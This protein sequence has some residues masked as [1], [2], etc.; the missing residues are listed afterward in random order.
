MASPKRGAPQR[1]QRKTGGSPREARPP[2]PAPIPPISTPTWTDNPYHRLPRLR[3]VLH[4][5][6]PTHRRTGT[7]PRRGRRR[8]VPGR[9]PAAVQRGLDA[10]GPRR[11][12]PPGRRPAPAAG[13]G[14]RWRAGALLGWRAPPRGWARGGEAGGTPHRR[15]RPPS[16]RDLQDRPVRLRRPEDGGGP[17]PPA[18]MRRSAL[19]TPRRTPAA[20]PSRPR[21]RHRTG[22]LGDRADG[23]SARRP[24]LVPPLPGRR[25][26]GGGPPP[27]RPG[28]IP[29]HLPI[30]AEC[31][32]DRG[33]RRRRDGGDSPV[34]ANS[35]T[36]RPRVGLLDP[37]HPRTQPIRPVMAGRASA[38]LR[39]TAAV[40]CPLPCTRPSCC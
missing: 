1:L 14:G 12:A 13:G 20:P 27:P 21:P 19:R 6:S 23:L 34:P 4:R 17:P 25:R 8:H 15:S 3:P 26:G 11:R 31:R 29:G 9:P 7:A 38:A 37:M 16:H 32:E 5:P 33:C 39:R 28:S 10:V 40:S 24:R 18:A 22:D 36:G 2:L 35:L 30:R